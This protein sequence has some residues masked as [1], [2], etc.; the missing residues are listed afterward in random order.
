MTRIT[1]AVFVA[2]SALAQSAPAEETV[3]VPKSMLTPH[4]QATVEQAALK[5]R[6]A[7]Y[8]EWVGLGKEIGQAVDSSLGALTERADQFAKTRVGT[9]TLALVAWKVLGQDAMG[10]LFAAILLFV[11]V[12][13]WLWSY[14]RMCVPRRVC[15]KRG[16]DGKPAE[17]QVVNQGPSDPRDFCKVSSAVHVVLALILAMCIGLSL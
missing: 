15:V 13:I 3:S 12:P 8:G 14:W 2:G 17:W 11:A 16:A 7:A 6:V 4:Q 1:L 10:M 5:Q 9:F